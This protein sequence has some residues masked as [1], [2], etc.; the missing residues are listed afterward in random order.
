MTDVPFRLG[1]DPG[2]DELVFLP[3]GGAGEIGMNLNLYGCDGRWIMVDCGVSFAERE[4]PG[5]DLIFPDPAFIEQRADDLL[6]IVLTH[7]HEDHLGAV[8]H[9][10]PRLQCPVY[11][12][13]FTAAMLES[14]LEE[15]RIRDLVPLHV[16]PLGGTIDL[17]P[18][19]I[20]FVALTHSIPEPN[21]LAI[22]TPQGLVLH[23]GDWKIDPEPMLGARTDQ[24][25][26]KRLGD[27]GVLAMVCDSTNVFSPG[28]SGSEA[29]VRESLAQLIGTLRGRVA[30][31]T[32]ASNVA[33]LES[34]AHA[35][36]LN[37]RHLVV[38]GRSMHRAI[39]CARKAGYIRELDNVLGESEAGYLPPDKVLYLVT[40]SQGE[41]RGAMARI[42]GGDHPHVVL[43]RGDTAIFSSK[44]IPGNEKPIGEMHNRLTARGVEI[45]TEQD[46]LVHVSGHPCRDELTEMYSWVRPHIA[47]PVHGEARHLAEH[48][49]LVQH[50][51][52][53]E[54]PLVQNGDILRLAP[55]SPELVG[56][57]TT[58]RL[59]LDG[60]HLVPEDGGALA[61]RRRLMFAGH[62]VVALVLDKSGRLMGAPRVTVAGVPEADACSE[63]VLSAVRDAVELLPRKRAQDDEAVR[64]AARRAGRRAASEATGKKPMTDIQ[65]IRLDL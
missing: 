27:E 3:L 12:T 65:V 53:P 43:E 28:R 42:A 44:I 49:R 41:P 17:A 1:F 52:V 25:T 16:V 51:N 23:T 14:K 33:R 57:V 36:R 56:R 63:A 22:R 32:F 54:T 10:W 50:L 46:H 60:R 31:T 45:L 40:G 62:V 19:S 47:V 37:D 9:L 30:V 59:A 13:P 24:E 29:T 8:A 20:R 61:A 38:V 34:V 26:L 7:A 35:A 15:Q 4:T 6:G 58:G 39:A 11:A 21:A 5:I 18:F 64:E 55:G 2:P 48:Q